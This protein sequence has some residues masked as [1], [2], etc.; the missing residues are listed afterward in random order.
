MTG[1]NVCKA[2]CSKY[3]FDG[4]A[5]NECY[6]DKCLPTDEVGIPVGSYTEKIA[7]DVWAYGLSNT[8]RPMTRIDFL[9]LPSVKALL[10]KHSMFEVFTFKALAPGYP[11]Y[12]DIHDAIQ[13]GVKDVIDVVKNI[14]PHDCLSTE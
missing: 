2:C 1:C 7:A 8:S 12:W 13:T 5:C 6:T 11:F 4:P 3:I 14:A 10:D 9:E